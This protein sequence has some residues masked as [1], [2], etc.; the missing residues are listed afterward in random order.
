MTG[1]RHLWP[2]LFAPPD[3]K[4]TY[5]HQGAKLTFQE[6]TLTPI[7]HPGVPRQLLL[8]VEAPRAGEALEAALVDVA[9]QGVAEGKEVI[10]VCQRTN[11]LSRNGNHLDMKCPVPR[12]P[13]AKIR[14]KTR[15]FLRRALDPHLSARTCTRRVWSTRSLDRRMRRPP[16]SA[17]PHAPPPGVL[18][19][20]P[21]GSC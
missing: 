5:S 20:A 12:Q 7:V 15:P 17:C 8:G 3:G 11:S 2:E 10:Y 1:K 4:S 9:L 13:V 16:P 18:P 19:V 14:G 21:G 6:E